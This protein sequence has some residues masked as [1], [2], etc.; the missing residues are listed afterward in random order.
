MSGSTQPSASASRTSASK[1]L[2]RWRRV[3][4]WG[5]I[6]VAIKVRAVSAAGKIGT[7]IRESRATVSKAG[8]C[9]TGKLVSRVGWR[10]SRGG[11]FFRGP[12]S[13]SNGREVSKERGRRLRRGRGWELG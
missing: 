11:N 9:F 4:A 3:S 10:E 5:E 1:T 6:A 8:G 2:Q 13:G 12:A 7:V